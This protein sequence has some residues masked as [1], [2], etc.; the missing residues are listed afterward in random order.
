AYLFRKQMAEADLIILNKQDT[1]TNAEFDELNQ[2]LKTLMGDIPIHSMSASTG[3]GIAEWVDVLLGT[4]S[5]GG[6]GGAGGIGRAGERILDIDYD[7][8]AQ[9]EAALGWLNATIDVTAASDFSPRELAE[10]LITEM[11]NRCTLMSFPIAHL[12]ILVVTNDSCDHIAV[13]DNM[14][15]PR[16]GGDAA[17]GFTCESSLIINARV[18]TH[19]EELAGL[20]RH[21]INAV[22]DELRATASVQQM[23][24]FSPPPPRPSHRF[25]EAVR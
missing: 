15:P 5:V 6:A 9:A 20:V 12:K 21:S 11:Q 10:R 2:A 23:E 14:N 4:D 1:V 3:R 22:T 24:S 8:Y 19:P 13:T 17:F 25:A 18:Q 7:T 16:W